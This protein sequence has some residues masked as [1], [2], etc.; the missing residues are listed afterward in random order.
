MSGGQ[1]LGAGSDHAMTESLKKP[2]PSSIA[3]EPGEP[4]SIVAD[5]PVVEGG[6][7][8]RHAAELTLLMVVGIWAANSLA[9]KWVVGEVPPIVFSFMRYLIS[10]VTLLAVLRWREGSVGIP[11]REILPMVGLGVVGF[12]IYQ[13]LWTTALS[14][15]TASNSALITA[16]APIWT[17]V[18]ATAIGADEFS[19]PKLAGMLVSVAGTVL[20]VGATH[21]FGFAGASAGDLMTLLATACWGGYVAL[22]APVLTRLSPLRMTTW[23]MG[24]GIVGMLPVA[25]WQL[26]G[27]DTSRIGPGVVV[28]LLYSSI[29]GASLANVALI[30]TTRTLGPSRTMSFMFMIP[31][32]V[33][34]GA[35]IFLQESIVPGQVVGVILVVLG[36]VVSR[37]TRFRGPARGRR[38]A[39]G[40]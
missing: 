14:H 34:V 15:T 4:A 1:R 39:G 37:S 27:L 2:H 19:R 24:F 35:A 6:G 33:V 40:S 38:D 16:A 9:L 7:L 13:D 25:L 5:E 23:T 3:S 17:M 26:P 22:G 10:F 11:R 21:G 8:T 12:G 31:A 30:G 28:V 32:L 29:L 20:V 36:I 18:I